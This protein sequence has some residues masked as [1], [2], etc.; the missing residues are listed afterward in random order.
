[1]RITFFT[2]AA[3]QATVEIWKRHGF[4]ATRVG[5]TVVTDGPTLWAVPVIYRHIGFDKVERLELARSS[6]LELPM[7]SEAGGL[8]GASVFGGSQST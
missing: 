6:P 5:Q 8:F 2:E 1:M 7:S 4:G 3:A